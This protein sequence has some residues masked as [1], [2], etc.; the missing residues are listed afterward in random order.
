M[1][2]RKLL[3]LVLLAAL[4]VSC[5]PRAAI[6][7]AESP[8]GRYVE[9]T[10]PMPEGMARA[11]NI[12][13]DEADRIT[14]F[15]FDYETKQATRAALNGDGTWTIDNPKWAREMREGENIQALTQSGD[16][17]YVLIIDYIDS[18]NFNYRILCESGGEVKSVELPGPS[19]ELHDK[20]A[21]LDG[22]AVLGDSMSGPVR[23]YEL[24]APKDPI[25]YDRAGGTIAAVDGTLISLSPREKAVMLYDIA[26]GGVRHEIKNDQLTEYDGLSTDGESIYITNADGVYR[27]A[28]SG[29]TWERVIDGSLTSLSRPSDH[30]VGMVPLGDEFYV[31]MN[32]DT[33]ESHLLKYTY[34]ASVSTK[35]S[36]ELNVYT[37]HDNPVVKQAAAQF[38][39]D[40]P[41]YLV[42]VTSLIP[43]QSAVTAADVIRTM[44]TELLA[45]QGPDVLVLDG[46]PADSYIEKGV[47]LDLSPVVRPLIEDGT[48]FSNLMEPFFAGEAIYQVPTTF[49]LPVLMGAPES[50]SG[51]T[52]LQTLVDFVRDADDGENPLIGRQLEDYFS[53]LTPYALSSW[54][55]ESGALDEV[56]F[57]G[58]LDAISLLFE[59]CGREY[60][61]EEADYRTFY[62]EAVNTG[63]FPPNPMSGMAGWLHELVQ[64]TRG[65]LTIMPMVL[66]GLSIDMVELSQLQQ[67][68]G[69]MIPVVSEKG[70]VYAPRGMLGVNAQTA[71]SEAAL[72]F[73]KTALKESVQGTDLYFGFSVNK[74]AFEASVEKE[75][76]EDYVVGTSV[77]DPETGEALSVSGRWPVRATRERVYALSAQATD[78]YI[79]DSTLMGMMTEALKPFFA[80]EMDAATAT[81]AVGAKVRAYL[82][83]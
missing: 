53:L 64:L 77:A 25:I 48:L 26:T 9:S 18:R 75:L 16:T 70:A 59:R 37:L 28:M 66:Q 22:W 79:E 5:L 1:H 7:E 41:D 8:K 68:Q 57:Q 33:S 83:E 65:R 27:A 35:P 21:V 23:G 43:E 47:L 36:K 20:L 49:T 81:R 14:L 13:R 63:R 17:T 12:T 10:L 76:S 78:A 69:E 40:Y 29:S 32:T 52:T 54:F 4:F 80:G 15:S 67:M 42:N 24:E 39:L 82:A 58:Y 30:L 19:H 56:A 61:G 72:N 34:D 3:S 55:D 73:I 31:L 71:Q 51:I 74:V 38:Q 45:G 50:L 11:F 46:M 62:Q 44:N 60:V 6:A 2:I